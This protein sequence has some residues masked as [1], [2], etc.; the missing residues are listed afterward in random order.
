[1][2]MEEN[3]GAVR[4]YSVGFLRALPTPDKQ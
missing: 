3:E 2:G 4:L 1:M